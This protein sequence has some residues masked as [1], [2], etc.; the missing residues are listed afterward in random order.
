MLMSWHPGVIS[1]V[2][3]PDESVNEDGVWPLA[4]NMWR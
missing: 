4:M 1:G 3:C 2:E